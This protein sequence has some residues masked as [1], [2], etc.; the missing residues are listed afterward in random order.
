MNIND[1]PKD[2]IFL[3]LG[4]VQISIFM[5]DD[6]NISYLNN[7]AKCKKCYEEKTKCFHLHIAEA[8]S[9]KSLRRVCKL[10]KNVI[11][12]RFRFAIA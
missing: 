7:L 10:W 3:I 9:R 2:C 8:W 1:L 6:D 12:E 5:D 11:D 4:F